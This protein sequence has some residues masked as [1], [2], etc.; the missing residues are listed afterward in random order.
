MICFTVAT[1]VT[2]GAAAAAAAGVAAR[3]VRSPAMTNAM[4]LINSATL[5]TNNQ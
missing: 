2:S 3:A 4:P 1:G 5:T